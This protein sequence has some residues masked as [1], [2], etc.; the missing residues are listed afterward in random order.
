MRERERRDS[1]GVTI[2][3]FISGSNSHV[4]RSVYFSSLMYDK[5]KKNR[6]NIV[7]DTV[8]GNCKIIIIGMYLFL[9]LIK[10]K[11]LLYYVCIIVYTYVSQVQWRATS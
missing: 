9:L 10:S 2:M 6:I 1:S 3:L 8:I 11:T 5:K 7:I 4:S